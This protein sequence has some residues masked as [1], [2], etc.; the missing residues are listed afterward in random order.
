MSKRH[1]FKHREYQT[2]P[3]DDAIFVLGLTVAL[4]AT[5]SVLLTTIH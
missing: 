3:R 5:V 1:K 4:I 2:D